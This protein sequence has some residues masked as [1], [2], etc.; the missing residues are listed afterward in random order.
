MKS[1]KDVKPFCGVCGW[2]LM[3]ATVCRFDNT[4]VAYHQ[5]CWDRKVADEKV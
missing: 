2:V 1:W 3:Y 4:D 5:S